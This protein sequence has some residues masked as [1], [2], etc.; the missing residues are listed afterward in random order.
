M[1][2]AKIFI[3]NKLQILKIIKLMKVKIYNPKIANIK[4]YKAD[5]S[6][7]FITKKLQILKIIRLMKVKKFLTNKLQLLK[8]VWLMKVKKL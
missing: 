1:M 2:K 6:K 8:I 7:K 5:E 3:T 4:Y